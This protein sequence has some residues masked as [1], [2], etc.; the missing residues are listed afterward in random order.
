[1]AQFPHDVPPYTTV[2]YFYYAAI[3]SG[4][5]EKPV[6]HWW[7]KY[8]LPQSERPRQAMRSL[9]RKA[10]KPPQ[11]QKNAALT[12]GTNKRAQSAHQ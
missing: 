3:K 5:W 6:Q 7:K 2:A 4:L 10:E 11:P 8:A 12:Q 9:T 1:M